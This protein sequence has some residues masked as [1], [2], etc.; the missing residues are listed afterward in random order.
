MCDN[1]GACEFAMGTRSV[2]DTLAKI[3]KHCIGEGS[4]RSLTNPIAHNPFI[5]ILFQHRHKTDIHTPYV[6][7]AHEHGLIPESQYAQK[8]TQT[9]ETVVDKRLFLTEYEYI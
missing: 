2:P 8:Y 7:H 6:T 5:R 4:W 3:L 1:N 9:L